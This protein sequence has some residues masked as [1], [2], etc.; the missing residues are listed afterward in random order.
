MTRN[1]TFRPTL[2]ELDALRDALLRAGS[3]ALELELGG[4]RLRMVPGGGGGVSADPAPAPPPARGIDSDGPGRLRLADPAG[5]AP[6]VTEG[7]MVRDGQLVA[8][9]EVGAALL[10]VHARVSGRIAAV[11]AADGEIVG[12]G[13]PLFRL[14]D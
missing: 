5:G 4:T 10:P 7:A 2:A 6:F 8:L 3:V 11:L 1:K 13:T 9:L 14:A 12:Y